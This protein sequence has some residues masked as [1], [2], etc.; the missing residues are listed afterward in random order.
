MPAL[1]PEVIALLREYW[2]P[3]NVRQLRNV[4]EG[5]VIA[6]DRPSLGL[7]DLPT[8]LL[9]GGGEAATP[10]PVLAD[11]PDASGGLKATE[12]A[13]ILATVRSCRGNLTRAARQLGIARSTLYETAG[14]TDWRDGV[15]RNC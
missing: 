8:E 2:W 3:G 10:A 7:E 6:T 14:T 9:P 1:Q 11:A 4:I 5:M 12:R 15:G 13:A